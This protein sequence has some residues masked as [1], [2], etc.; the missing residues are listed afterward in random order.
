MTATASCRRVAAV[1]VALVAAATV[2]AGCSSDADPSAVEIADPWVRPSAEVANEAEAYLDLTAETDD[3]L[4]EVEVDPDLAAGASLVESAPTD[5]PDAD[6]A[7]STVARSPIDEVDLPAGETVALE[8]GGRHIV[9]VGLTEAVE[10]GDEIDLTLS[11]R[12]GA[13]ET[14]TAEVRDE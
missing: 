4:V 11:F 7:D 3:A 5:A 10:A 6:G 2:G 14:V 12:G 13:T 9:L 1:G 8:P